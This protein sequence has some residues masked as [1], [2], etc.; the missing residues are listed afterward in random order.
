MNDKVNSSRDDFLKFV[1]RLTIITIFLVDPPML[2]FSYYG[3]AGIGKYPIWII[4]AGFLT[5]AAVLGT[6][7]VF[8][9]KYLVNKLFDKSNFN[10]AVVSSLI[11]FL[12]I[13]CSN[14]HWTLF[15]NVPAYA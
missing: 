2:L 10:F 6:V 13:S 1:T 4:L 12:G 9:L 15:R 5:A 7:I 3:F 14:F 11:V 8:L